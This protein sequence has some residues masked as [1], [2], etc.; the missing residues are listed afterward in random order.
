MSRNAQIKRLLAKVF[1]REAAKGV[2]VQTFAQISDSQ[3]EY[4]AIHQAF[5]RD[6]WCPSQSSWNKPEDF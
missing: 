1:Q 2:T 3:K 4:L 5:S 6:E